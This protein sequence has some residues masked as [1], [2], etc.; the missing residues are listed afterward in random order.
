MGD[1]KKGREG[2]KRSYMEEVGR[3]N[4][5]DENDLVESSGKGKA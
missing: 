4:H 2:M 1:R 3:R 5:D